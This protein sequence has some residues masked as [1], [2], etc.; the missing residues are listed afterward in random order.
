MAK[1][2]ALN[3]Q[4]HGDCSLAL[5]S[6]PW[7]YFTLGSGPGNQV[8]PVFLLTNEDSNVEC[9]ASRAD[10]LAIGISPYYV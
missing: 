9:L 3:I 10:V 2:S 6:W 5:S 8:W 7:T 1:S 4:S